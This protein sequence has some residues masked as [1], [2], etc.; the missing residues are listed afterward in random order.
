MEHHIE[1]LIW[2]SR[3]PIVVAVLVSILLAFG[4]L[5]MAAVDA[6]YV[7][8]GLVEY[9]A[10]ALGT[11]GRA[12]RRAATI[13][14]IVKAIDGFLIAAIMLIFAYGLY[15]LF[16][17]R[18][19]AASRSESAPRLLQVRSLDDLKNRLA[20][21]VLLVL[22]IEF[23][24]HALKMIYASPSDLLLLAAGTLLVAGA[25]RLSNL[26]VGGEPASAAPLPQ[27]PAPGA[28]YRE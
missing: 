11:E 18:I 25:L 27:P 8:A 15:E 21:V 10:T 16:V 28:N 1:R 19:R 14:G 13:T 7:L 3:L 12:E 20:K 5:F 6:A 2:A 4:A 9:P 17:G 24:Q 22:V 23:F 26:K